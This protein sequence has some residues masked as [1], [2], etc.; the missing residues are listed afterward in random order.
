[1]SSGDQKADL[2]RQ[3]ARVTAWAAAQQIPVDKVVA[4]VGCALKGHRREVLALLSSRW[5]IGSWWMPL[6]LMTTSCGL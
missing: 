3:V 6:G 5:C 4:E 2:D 1:V